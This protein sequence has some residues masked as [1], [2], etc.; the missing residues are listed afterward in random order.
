M[1]VCLCCHTMRR[2]GFS[3]VADS[4][5]MPRDTDWH[6][7]RYKAAALSALACRHTQVLQTCATQGSFPGAWCYDTRLAVVP[8]KLRVAQV[9]LLLSYM[10][11]SA[12]FRLHQSRGMHRNH[13]LRITYRAMLIDKSPLHVAVLMLPVPFTLSQAGCDGPTARGANSG[14][15]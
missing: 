4:S 5:M 12:D 11:K 1:L 2:C 8:Q 9:R 14:S 7:Q 13:P 10:Q 15:I 3:T 6:I